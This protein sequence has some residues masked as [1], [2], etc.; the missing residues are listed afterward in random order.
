MTATVSTERATTV[1]APRGLPSGKVLPVRS[2]IS[3]KCLGLM[4]AALLVLQ[5][6]LLHIAIHPVLSE[7]EGS[8]PGLASGTPL[9]KG[10]SGPVYQPWPVGE[11]P[12][13]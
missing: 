9:R 11:T 8:I 6:S 10:D 1:S 3:Q 5:L 4:A 12:S 7:A 2:K 13:G